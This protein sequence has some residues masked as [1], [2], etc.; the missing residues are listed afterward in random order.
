MTAARKP[1]GKGAFS[2]APPLLSEGAVVY[3]P[4]EALSAPDDLR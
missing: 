3:E 1:S 2:L 4:F